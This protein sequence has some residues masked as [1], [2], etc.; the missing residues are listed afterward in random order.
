MK[1][2][3]FFIETKHLND[4]TLKMIFEKLAIPERI[5]KGASVA[6]KLH[7]GEIDNYTHLRPDLV[8]KLVDLLKG[9]KARPFLTDTN[10]LYRHQRSNTFDH[11]RTAAAHGFTSESMGC[12]IIIAD[13]LRSWG[14]TVT[15]DSPYRL[16]EIE[17]ALGIADAD[18]LITLTHLTFHHVVGLGGAIKNL[19]MGCVCRGTKLLCHAVPGATVKLNHDRCIVC[20][21]CVEICPGSAYEKVE[22]K[23]EFSPEK[24]VGCG[25]CIHH[26]PVQAISPRWDTP[27]GEVHKGLIDSARGVL[28]AMEGKPLFHLMVLM[29]VTLQCDCCPT[30]QRI[31]PD[32]GILGSTD[33]VALDRVAQDL[34]AQAPPSPGVAGAEGTDK[35]QTHY[36][37]IDMNAYWGFCT[38]ARIGTTNYNLQPIAP[39]SRR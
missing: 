28:Q 39:P 25:D 9:Q 22:G 7:F 1:A 37:E 38:G 19:A 31:V 12:P 20:G 2:D 17:V 32:I 13:G 36:P 30:T 6:L 21:T 23:I 34:L 4:R 5:P 16:N 26:C 35:L 14:R 3:V 8:K 18:A 27:R 10:T 29:D 15:L 33:P 24:C 11:L